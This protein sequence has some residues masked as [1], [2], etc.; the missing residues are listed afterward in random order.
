MNKPKEHLRQQVE[1]MRWCIRRMEK[2]LEV[3]EETLEGMKDDN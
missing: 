1:L 2:E 3:L